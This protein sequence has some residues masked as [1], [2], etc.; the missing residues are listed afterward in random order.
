MAEFC[1]DCW[2]EINGFSDPPEAYVLSW[3]YDL[4]EGCGQWKR[5]VVRRRKNLLSY[6]LHKLIRIIK[7]RR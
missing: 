7:T 4:C 6:F 5:V 2:N 3:D 1:P